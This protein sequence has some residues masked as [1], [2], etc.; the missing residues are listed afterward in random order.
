MVNG[1]QKALASFDIQPGTFHDV[2]LP[3]TNYE[4]R[5]SVRYTGNIGLPGHF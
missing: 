2:E 4:E 3:F 5:D 1:N